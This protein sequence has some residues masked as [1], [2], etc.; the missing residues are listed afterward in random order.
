M[1]RRRDDGREMILS[2]EDVTFDVC[3][4][5]ERLRLSQIKSSEFGG[6]R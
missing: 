6:T 2:S 4:K 3:V 1:C 5:I